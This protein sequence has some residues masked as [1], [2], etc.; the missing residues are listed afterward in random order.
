MWQIP[1][2]NAVRSNSRCLVPPGT[3]KF[4]SFD[5]YH[6]RMCDT[7]RRLLGLL[8]VLQI[9]QINVCYIRKLLGNLVK[10]S[11]RNS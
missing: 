6:I 7:L 3:L 9:T 8:E 10:V 5:R 1:R 2:H 11:I 4:S